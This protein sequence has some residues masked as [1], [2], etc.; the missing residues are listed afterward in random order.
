MERLWAPWRMTYL[1]SEEMPGSCIFCL[2]GGSEQHEEKLVLFRDSHALVMMNRYPYTCGHLLVVPTRHAASVT[3]LEPEEMNRLGLLLRASVGILKRMLRCEGFNLGMNLGHIAGAGVADHLHWHLVP[4][5]GGDT[6]FLPVL[7][8]TRVINQ[9]LA[10]TYA[11]LR[12]E[13]ELLHWTG[14]EYTT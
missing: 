13:F 11:E 14:T 3:E 8:D 7:S 2:T 6:N 5:W 1:R 10:E 4:R 12:G 9:Y